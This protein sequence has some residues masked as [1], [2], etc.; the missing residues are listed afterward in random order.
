MRLSGGIA[1]QMHSVLTTARGDIL[2]V[3]AVFALYF[4]SSGIESLRIGLNRAYGLSEKRPWWL[5]RLE[6]IGYVLVGALGLLSL[7]FLVVLG[8]LIFRAAL[9]L[10]AVARAAGK[11]FRYRRAS[12]SR[13]SC[14]LSR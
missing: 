6:S 8:P 14:S 2:T 10:C 3:G 12:R 4:S 13:P 9:V 5:L 7:A 1:G 11:P